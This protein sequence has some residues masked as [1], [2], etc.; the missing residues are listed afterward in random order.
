M[1]QEVAQATA[2][3]S[4]RDLIIQLS[5][6][7]AS[8]LF[9]LGLRSLTRPNDARLGMQ[10]AAGGMLF[11]VIG[12]LLN[13]N[14]I[15]YQWIVIGLVVG[16]AIGYPMAMRIPMTAMPQFI[17]FSHAFGAMAATLVGIVEYRAAWVPDAA[18]VIQDSLVAAR[19]RSDSKY[20]SAP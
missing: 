14:I 12:T 4:A 3:M 16:A 20:C 15:T 1:L 19:P 8:I 18:G 7:I 17:A 11:A 13:S 6:L 10:Q 5:Y 9:I 2:A